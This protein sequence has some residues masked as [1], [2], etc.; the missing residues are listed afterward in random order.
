[1]RECRRAISFAVLVLHWWTN[2]AN[3]LKLS[4]NY[5]KHQSRPAETNRLGFLRYLT[6]VD[7]SNTHRQKKPL[8]SLSTTRSS[9]QTALLLSTSSTSS[10]HSRRPSTMETSPFRKRLPLLSDAEVTQLNDDFARRRN[11]LKCHKC[12][13]VGRLRKAGSYS[14]D[15]PVPIYRCDQCNKTTMLISAT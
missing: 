5:F 1:M 6:L 15:R 4:A 8:T 13:T 7:E 12:G 9:R 14:T 11:S 10:P 2:D 3:P